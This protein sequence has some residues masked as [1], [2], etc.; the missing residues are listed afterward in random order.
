VTLPSDPAAQTGAGAS[1]FTRV[2]QEQ[3]QDQ[4]QQGQ[5]DQQEPEQQQQ[6]QQEQHEE[7][8]QQSGNQPPDN[9]W[10]LVNEQV[11]MYVKDFALDLDPEAAHGLSDIIADI[12]QQDAQ[13][14][15]DPGLEDD[16]AELREL[17]GVAEEPEGQ[18]T[19]IDSSDAPD[20]DSQKE[21]DRLLANLHLYTYGLECTRLFTGHSRLLHGHLGPP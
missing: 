18:D 19:P 17:L 13:D 7:P 3:Q 8:V 1:G 20:A 2:E 21:L 5:L 16:L 4:Q 15:E 9:L 12:L 14:E 11:Q 10:Q 6:Q